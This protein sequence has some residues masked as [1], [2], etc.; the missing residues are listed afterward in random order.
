[1]KVINWYHNGDVLW[2]GESI[3]N[4]GFATKAICPVNRCVCVC[5]REIERGR[6]RE[7][8]RKREREGGGGR[9]GEGGS[10]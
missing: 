2:N 8:E 7:R 3:D 9:V 5:E 4:H 1:M 10:E 6:G